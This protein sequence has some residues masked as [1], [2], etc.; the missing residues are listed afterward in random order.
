[1]LACGEPGQLGGACMCICVCRACVHTPTCHS[2]KQHLGKA[3]SL[4]WDMESSAKESML[5]NRVPCI[6]GMLMPTD[7]NSSHSKLQPPRS[8]KVFWVMLR[9]NPACSQR[10]FGDREKHMGLR[11]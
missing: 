4:L 2:G 7:G 5:W 3:P 8:R 1:M 10:R 6:C 11:S 9:E